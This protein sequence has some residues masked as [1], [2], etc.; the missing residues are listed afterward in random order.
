MF[1]NLYVIIIEKSYKKYLYKL[2]KMQRLFLRQFSNT[3]TIWGTIS[4]AKVAAA[5]KKNVILVPQK[6]VELRERKK[7]EEFNSK[8]V[9]NCSARKLL[10][11]LLGR[12]F[13]EDEK[14]GV[15]TPFTSKELDVIFKQKN[16]RLIYKVLGTSGMQ[17]KDSMIVNNDVE[18]FLERG[19]LYRAEQLAKLARHQGLFAYG[20]ILKYLLQRGQVNDAFDIFMDLR[21]RGYEIKGRLYNVLLSGYGD[22]I[23]KSYNGTEVSHEKVERLFRAFQ[24]DHLSGKQDISVIHVNSLLK[25]LRKS[26]RVDLGLSLFDSLK[27]SQSGHSRIKP[28]VRTYTETLR[29]LAIA[30]PERDGLSYKDII[31]R[32]E[33]IFYNSQNNRNIKVDAFLV[34]AYASIYAYSDDLMLR[35]RA[36]TIYRE[37]FRI[38]SLEEIKQPVDY[39]VY[40]QK[41]WEKIQSNGTKRFFIGANRPSLLETDQINAAKSKRFEPDDA[42]IR[43]YTELCKLFKIPCTYK[44]PE[45]RGK[46]TETPAKQTSNVKAE[47]A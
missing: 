40:N 45:R 46:I 23:S 25:V 10:G 28:D 31:K 21:K 34:R 24:K 43:S 17:I 20:T 27:E 37:W 32:A 33:V 41:M 35:A 8:P 26:K 4:K 18:K 5:I 44:P 7:L 12:D 19:E 42:I 38:S 36:V 15:L 39:N 22:T 2:I 16:L 14:I 29:L 1:N 6:E 47:V 9:T 30:E 3:P 11:E 13:K